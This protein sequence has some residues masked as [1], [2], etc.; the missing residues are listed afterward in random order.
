MS[1]R[2]VLAWLAGLVAAPG[3]VVAGKPDA[4]IAAT[5][6]RAIGVPMLR[7]I[8]GPEAFLPLRPAS[9]SLAPMTHAVRLELD[10][11][12]GLP[13]MLRRIDAGLARLRGDAGHDGA[14]CLTPAEFRAFMRATRPAPIED[15]A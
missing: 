15:T 13:D 1:R 3:A 8:A 2:S 11:A 12:T 10:S 4:I 14:C 7:G 5:H 6:G 9:A